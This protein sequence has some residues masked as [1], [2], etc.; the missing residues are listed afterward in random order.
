MVREGPPGYDDL[1]GDA[2]QH[3]ERHPET[4]PFHDLNVEGVGII[5]ARYPLPNAV[6]VLV[7]AYRSKEQHIAGI[8]RFIDHHVEDGHRPLLQGMMLGQYPYDTLERVAAAIATRGSAR[9]YLAVV[10]LAVTTAYNWRDVRQYISE[11]GIEPMALPSMGRLLDYTEKMMRAACTS[12]SE[13]EQLQDRLY[14]PHAYLYQAADVAAA[15]VRP[16]GFE[17]PEQVAA[18]NANAFAKLTGAR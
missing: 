10:I 18:E 6:P 17:N 2:E 11:K 4:S 8:K 9:P 12:E 14:G 16:A 13:L 7:S 15:D 5:R 3:A 1:A